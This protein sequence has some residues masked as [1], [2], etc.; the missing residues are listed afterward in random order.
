MFVFFFLVNKKV[1]FDDRRMFWLLSPRLNRNSVI[2]GGSRPAWGGGEGDI[3]WIARP[4]DTR[5]ALRQ[6]HQEGASSCQN[7]TLLYTTHFEEWLNNSRILAENDLGSVC[8]QEIASRP[9]VI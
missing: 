7:K 5:C 2:N 9:F 1:L 8:P 6:Y 3:W 4:S